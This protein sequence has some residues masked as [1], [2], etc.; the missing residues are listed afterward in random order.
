MRWV[1]IQRFNS[2]HN[3]IYISAGLID[4]RI[5]QAEICFGKKSEN[6]VVIQL[7]AG[8]KG[9]LRM[10]GSLMDSL[11]L[12]ASLKYQI[13]I[14]KNRVRIGP[15][16]ALLLGRQCIYYSDKNMAD[17]TDALSCYEKTGGLIYAFT[18]AGI[19]YEKRQIH[20]L[21][22]G[23]DKVWHYGSFPYPD[24]IFRRGFIGNESKIQKIRQDVCNTIFNERGRDKWEM[25]QL[26]AK[27]KAVRPFLPD[28]CALSNPQIVLSHL[29]KY[30]V[31]ILK[32]TDLSRGRGIFI[33]RM[34]SSQ[35]IEITDCQKKES[36][37]TIIRQPE[38]DRFLKRGGFFAH[39][40]IVQN[41]LDLATVNGNPFDIR[42]VMQKRQNNK[43]KCSGIECRIAGGDNLISNIAR[44]GRALSVNR[45]LLLAFGPNIPFGRIKKQIVDIAKSIC[46]CIDQTGELF[47]EFGLDIAIDKN[48]HLWFIEANVRPSF[49]G[50]RRMDYK[51]YLYICS[52]PI[53]YA[54]YLAGFESDGNM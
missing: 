37:I 47:A 25:H 5:K 11:C 9:I 43:W 4:S 46:K 20:G 12:K 41:R 35:E 33:L 10:S 22:F 28:T 14:E 50:F 42:V 16:I 6:S 23:N 52:R 29:K 38:L 49:K 40:Y 21:Y 44:G 19:E 8:N 45:T 36:N 27:D 31:V 39:H 54:A 48:R 34:K 17:Y 2:N 18:P 15:V 30:T 3:V 26:L 24:V 53:V 1:N 32:P 51:N 7:A 13:R